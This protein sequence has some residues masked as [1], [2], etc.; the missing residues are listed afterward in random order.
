MISMLRFAIKYDIN[1]L[2]I[3]NAI[4]QYNLIDRETHKLRNEY[5]E[6]EL[7]NAVFRYLTCINRREEKQRDMLIKRTKRR[8][9][10]INYLIS[11]NPN[12]PES[13]DETKRPED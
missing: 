5:D 8:S 1:T 10:V 3:Q 4:Y 7:Y 11:H 12:L 2:D 6:I 9:E 13:N